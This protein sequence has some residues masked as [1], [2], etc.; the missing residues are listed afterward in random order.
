TGHADAAGAAD[1]TDTQV[2]TVDGPPIVGSA[3]DLTNQKDEQRTLI[4][5]LETELAAEVAV[6]AECPAAGHTGHA[7]PTA[8]AAATDSSEGPGGAQSAACTE[9][10]QRTP[11]TE[12][13]QGTRCTERTQGTD[14][15]ECTQGTEAAAQRAE[16]AYAQGTEAAY[17]QGTEAAGAQGTKAA[18]TQ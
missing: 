14:T 10:T 8:D 15:A 3:D 16:A 6:L 12:R 9:R 7:Q 18:D 11:C 17:A 4:A 5:T 2:G 13:P 1:T